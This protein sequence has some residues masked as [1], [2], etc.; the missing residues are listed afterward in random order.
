[1]LKR[2]GKI[3]D[4]DLAL[5]LGVSFQFVAQK[6][7]ELGIPAKR[8]SSLKWT[9]EVVSKMGKISDAAIA[10]ELGCTTGLV[11]LKRTELGISAFC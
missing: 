1:M 11:R 9:K 5:E 6:R 10:K 2:V 3:P 8:R 4:E 7:L